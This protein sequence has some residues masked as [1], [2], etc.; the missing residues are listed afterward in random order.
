MFLRLI[1]SGITADYQSVGTG[2]AR[3]FEARMRREPL[4]AVGT[5]ASG[6]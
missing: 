5:P 4:V 1:S 6:L 2:I 3:D